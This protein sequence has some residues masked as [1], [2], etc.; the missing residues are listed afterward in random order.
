MIGSG[1]L[2]VAVALLWHHRRHVEVIAALS[3][4]GVGGVLLTVFGILL[5][6]NAA[7]WG[8]SYALGPG[9]AV[10]TGTTVA[11]GDVVLGAVPAVP[12]LT[13][14]PE[15]GPGSPAG[16][17]VLVVPVLAGVLIGLT[18]ERR[19]AAPGAPAAPAPA[20][21]GRAAVGSAA[22]AGALAGLLLGALAWCSGGALGAG[23]MA[24][25]GP[26][27][28]RVALFGVLLLGPVAAVTV[29]CHRLWVARRSPEPADA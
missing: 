10:G 5:L 27:W 1:S 4:G 3:P 22:G 23:R 25:L 24:E 15:S 16:Y 12:L 20:P 17:A 28:W 14:L 19:L 9:F 21:S 6:P 18:V 7:L 29:L 13:A 8:A 11:P 26:S 2:I